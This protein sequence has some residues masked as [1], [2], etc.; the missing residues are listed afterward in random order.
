MALHCPVCY[1][2]N[3]E[4]K[5]RLEKKTFTVTGKKQS[6]KA[7]ATFNLLP[8]PSKP[9]VSVKTVLLVKKFPGK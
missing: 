4:W 7:P 2:E 1:E 9:N 3:A 8:H 5:F 6:N